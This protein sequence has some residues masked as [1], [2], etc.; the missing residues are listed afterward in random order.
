VRGSTADEI[1]G[2]GRSG[3]ARARVLSV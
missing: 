3:V 2:V 1:L